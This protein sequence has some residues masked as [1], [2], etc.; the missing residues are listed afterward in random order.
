MER[1]ILVLAFVLCIIS[2][3]QAIALY[4]QYRMNPKYP[5]VLWWLKG[6]VIQ[7]VGYCTLLAVNSKSFFSISNFAFP[8][9]VFGQ[10][11]YYHGIKVLL[12]QKGNRM[13]YIMF[14]LVFLIFNSY[15]T[16]FIDS[17]VIRSVIEAIAIMLI[18][19][20]SAIRLFHNKEEMLARS[21][22]FAGIIYVIQASFLAFYTV[23]IV[24]ISEIYTYQAFRVSS[25]RMA[26]YI[27]PILTSMLSVFAL[28]MMVNQCLNFENL[29]LVVQLKEEKKAA[30]LNAITDSLTGLM[31]RRFFDNMF[32][33]EFKRSKRSKLPLSLLMIDIDYF[34]NYND[35]YG[36][37]EGDHCLTMLGTAF[38]KIVSRTA[39]IVGRYG[40]EEFYVVLPETDE[41]GA[42]T[43]AN[44]IKEAI[45]ELRIRNNAS[46]IASNVT[47]SIG[48]ATLYTKEFQKPEDLIKMAD[49][50]MYQAKENGRNQIVSYS[51][52]KG[53]LE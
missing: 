28:I 45:D 37:L 14:Y 25:I 29:T 46:K 7:A 11:L 38:R 17:I 21:T 31:N 53:N 40:G 12:K 10:L 4:I 27:M 52:M 6:A 47:I 32:P 1:S 42:K 51:E 48:A 39:D 36:H 24:A 26:A 34:K 35:S 30:E 33:L 16:F 50:A 44:K 22:R 2:I 5:C 9:I 15:F 19:F 13:V 23:H 18:L 3:G 43:V 8:L 20:F 49:L 41:D